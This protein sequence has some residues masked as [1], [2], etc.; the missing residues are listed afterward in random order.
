MV[1]EMLQQHGF[2]FIVLAR[3]RSKNRILRQN[4]IV[5]QFKLVEVRQNLIISPSM[6]PTSLLAHC[7]LPL[8]CEKTPMRFEMRLKHSKNQDETWKKNGYLIR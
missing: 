3:P 2:N 6:P 8:Q 5:E 1:V 4:V 7:Y